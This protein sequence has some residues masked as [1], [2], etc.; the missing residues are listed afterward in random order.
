MIKGIKTI[1]KNEQEKK[2]EK[3]AK[4]NLNL[5]IKMSLKKYLN[6]EAIKLSS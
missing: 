1:I 3:S 4:I 6:L 2:I 5:L